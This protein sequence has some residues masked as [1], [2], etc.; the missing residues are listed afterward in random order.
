MHPLRLLHFAVIA[1]TLS[2]CAIAP[3]R[4]KRV[5]KGDRVAM[6]SLLSL[7]VKDPHGATGHDA[8][9]HFIERWKDGGCR[10]KDVIQPTA[11]GAGPAFRVS[12]SGHAP[13]LYP[14][15]YFDEIRPVEDFLVKKLPYHRRDGV[16]VPL[17]ALRENR[18][19]EPIETYFPPEAITRP[20]TAVLHPGKMRDGTQ[21]IHIELLCPLAKDRVTCKGVS[22]PLAADFTTP[23]AAL[24]A[25]CGKLNQVRVL[26]MISREQQR[27]PQLY[28]MEPYDPKKEPLI[29]IHGLLSSP[30]AWSE[31]SND[32][33]AS[34]EIRK[35]YQIW[36]YLYN[37]SAPALYS[38]RLLREQLRDLRKLIDPKGRDPASKRMTLL[39]HS[40]GGIVGKA[41]SLQPGDVLWKAALTVPKESLRVSKADRATLNE[42]FEWKADP[43]VHRIIFVATPHRGSDF[44]D[45]TVGKIGRILTKPPNAFQA[46][47]Q[48]I[49]GAN[50]GVF[51]P[52]YVDLGNG[53][54]DSV[55][56][57][58]PRQPTFKLLTQMPF[59][60]GVKTHSI[61]GNRGKTGP[62]EESSD[63]VVPYSSS[64]IDGVLSEK[65][66]PFGH[67]TF[68][69]PEAVAEIIRILK[70]R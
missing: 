50:P 1:L 44:A 60:K 34:E 65:I 26:D 40:M 19:A 33:W 11:G 27:K 15:H 4:V 37:T 56:T 29:M 55:S 38:S 57:L 16:G 2:N 45:S 25:R 7:A 23:W 62:L 66:V 22:R 28:L 5:V 68:R 9:G 8:L 24:L 54:L 17:M 31:L 12:F 6:H 39:T 51:T 53:K 49:S 30:L 67:S 47:Y 46:F 52:D 21:E 41:L 64:H 61:I 35:R 59:R 10:D 42:A 48:R 43:A 69:H 18:A 14:L 3:A 13:G 70:L 20:L 36:H 32:L 63:G 58:S